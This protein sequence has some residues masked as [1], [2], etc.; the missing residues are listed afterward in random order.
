[1]E[2]ELIQN[3]GSLLDNV[4]NNYSESHDRRTVA[5]IKN[6]LLCIEFR[7][8]FRA[9]REDELR[10]QISLLKE[11]ALSFIKSRHDMIKKGFKENTGKSLKTKSCSEND[12]IETLTTSFHNPVRTIKYV[13]TVCYEVS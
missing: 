1:M 11:E 6:N 13:Y 9:A 10:R 5:C 4:Y 3:L 12:N 8:I 7:T 2:Y